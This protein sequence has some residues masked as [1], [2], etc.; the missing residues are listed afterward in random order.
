MA[1]ELY[2]N[3]EW[4]STN[5]NIDGTPEFVNSVKVLLGQIWNLKGKQEAI[6]EG[7]RQTVDNNVGKSFIRELDGAG[8]R[9][10]IKTGSSFACAASTD[11]AY[12]KLVGTSWYNR[13]VAIPLLMNAIARSP[14][15]ISTLARQL[16][17]PGPG[18]TNYAFT[19]GQIEAL[20]RAGV[21]RGGGSRIVS[22]STFLRMRN[23]GRRKVQTLI[24]DA[25]SAWDEALSLYISDETATGHPPIE[26]GQR[27][28]VC[29]KL[30]PWLDKGDGNG[31]TV[32]CNFLSTETT[33][34]FDGTK[35][36][37]PMAIAFAH[38]LVHAYYSL[39]GTRLYRE[40]TREDEALTTGLPPEHFRKYSENR[41][42]VLWPEERLNLRLFYAFGSNICPYCGS[43]NGQDRR[44][45]AA[46][47]RRGGPT[48][49]I[50]RNCGS[51]GE[52]I[53][54]PQ[55]LQ[56]PGGLLPESEL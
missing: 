30:E 5:I 4:T 52:E 2:S 9:I 40:G 41:F 34:Y 21:Y 51:C 43:S 27:S 18:I 1:H 10:N 36:Q 45:P 12:Y 19:P 44:I 28:L 26:S 50:I 53:M 38:E 35:K 25:A 47:R 3:S 20:V 39:T 46:Q 24:R 8:Y 23:Q 14:Y 55:D 49:E 31:A 22:P 54:Q 32:T 29:R 6:V 11:R 16:A 56:G 13:A 48:I 42:R 7:V 17:A 15:D 33:C 37:R